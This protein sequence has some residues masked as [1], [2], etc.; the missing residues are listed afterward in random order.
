MSFDD[1]DGPIKSSVQ[2][3]KEIW[4]VAPYCD[5]SGLQ[6]FRSESDARKFAV[7]K[8]SEVGGSVYIYKAEA[9]SQAIPVAAQLAPV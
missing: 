1:G 2:R 4:I 6:A 9:T 8:A 7:A 3:D 5:C